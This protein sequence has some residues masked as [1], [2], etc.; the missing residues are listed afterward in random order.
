MGDQTLSLKPKAQRVRRASINGVRHVLKTD[1]Q[2]PNFH[3]RW[4]NDTGDRITIFKERGYEFVTDPNVKVG[5]RRVEES[6]D[7]TASPIVANVGGGVKAYYMRIPREWH[8]EDQQEKQKQVDT[9]EASIKGEAVA[10][11]DYGKLE[12]NRAK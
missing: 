11:A 3:Y 7:K 2:D 5:D 8:E 4:V 6:Q 10:G 9:I 12:V 1:G